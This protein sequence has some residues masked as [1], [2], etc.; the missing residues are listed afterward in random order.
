MLFFF[1]QRESMIASYPLS[2]NRFF[3]VCGKGK[4]ILKH[5]AL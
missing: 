3:F 5:D 4:K 2:D 1:S